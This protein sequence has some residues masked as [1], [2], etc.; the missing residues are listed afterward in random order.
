M[1]YFELGNENGHTLP[2]EDKPGVIAMVVPSLNDPFVTGIL[3]HLQKSFATVGF[4]FCVI[5]KDADDARYDRMINAFKKFYSGMIL[6]GEVAD[7]KTI[8]TLKS[9]DYP[10]VVIDKENPATRLNAV[11]C[12]YAFGSNLV[13]K[14][15][16]GLS[17]N[18]VLIISE[19]GTN[20]KDVS[21]LL[22]SLDGLQGTERPVVVDCCTSLPDNGADFN[23]LEKYLRPPYRTEIIIAMQS[24]TVYPLL[25]YLNQLKIRVPNDVALVSMQEGIAFDLIAPTI[26]ALRKPLSAMA[27]KT[28]T[29]LWTEIKN[30]GKS[31]FVRQINLNPELIVRSSCGSYR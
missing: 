10:F 5:S 15:I 27:L 23:Q 31:K 4:G 3:P 2:I 7:D 28:A 9:T 8:R 6:V 1:G 24:V 20:Q 18:N 11:N 19:T 14:H 25:S 13:G 30:S 21:T 22:G 29:M 12:D 16:K 17:Y 26:T